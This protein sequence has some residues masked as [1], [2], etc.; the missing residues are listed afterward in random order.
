M[1]VHVCA[2][3]IV[4]YAVN[5]LGHFSRVGSGAE[6]YPLTPGTSMF[7]NK[8]PCVPFFY[9]EPLSHG[10]VLVGRWEG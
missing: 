7:C 4:S 9:L 6:Q 5:E 2:P 10:P 1:C 8:G 3:W